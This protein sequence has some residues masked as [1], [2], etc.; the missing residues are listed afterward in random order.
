MQKL[1]KLKLAKS[2][3]IIGHNNK[4]QRLTTTIGHRRPTIDLCQIIIR[5]VYHLNIGL[6]CKRTVSQPKQ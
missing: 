6:T 2:S 1:A 3:V 4:T 5:E